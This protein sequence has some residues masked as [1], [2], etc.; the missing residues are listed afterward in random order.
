MN[1]Q[2]KTTG[3][4]TSPSLTGHIEAKVGELVKFIHIEK[5]E[6]E[7]REAKEGKHPPVEAFVEIGRTYGGQKKGDDVYRAEIQLRVPGTERIVVRAES[8]DVRKALEKARQEMKTRLRR[9]KDKQRAKL[10]KSSK[11]KQIFRLGISSGEEKKE[12]N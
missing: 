11:V 8:W 6:K 2:I 3:F 12:E 1:V 4:E 9:H 10:R 7:A 5:D